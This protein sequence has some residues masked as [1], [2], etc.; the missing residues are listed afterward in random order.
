MLA[1]EEEA[2]TNETGGS[3]HDLEAKKNTKNEDGDLERKGRRRNSLVSI[4]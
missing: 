1:V 3:R 4:R 2:E